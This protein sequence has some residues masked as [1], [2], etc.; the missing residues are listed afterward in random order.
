MNGAGKLDIYMHK[1]ESRLIHLNMCLTKVKVVKSIPGI[2]V[3][4]SQDKVLPFPWRKWSNVVKLSEVSSCSTQEMALYW[5]LCWV[6]MCAYWTFSSYSSQIS[7]AEWKPILLSSC[8]VCIHL[9][10]A[11]LFFSL[12][13]NDRGGWRK[14]FTAIHHPIHLIVKLFCRGYL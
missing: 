11:T 8:I 9:A 13:G 3:S 1:I 10:V 12:L 7:L 14:T 2:S 6:F 5:G 4:A